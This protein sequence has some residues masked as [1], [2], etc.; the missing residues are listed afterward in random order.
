MDKNSL[1][2]RITIGI[3][4]SL[5]IVAS[6]ITGFSVYTTKSYLQ[7]EVRQKLQ[8][9]YQGMQQMFS[10][11][12]DNALAHAQALSRN[13]HIIEAAKRRDAQALFR[14]TTPLMKDG[15]LDYMVITDPKGFAII[16]TH[17]PGKIPKP[18]DSIAN[19][20]NVAQ[21]IAGKPFVGIEEGKVVRLSVRAG[22]PLY[23]ETGALVGVIST[24]YVI[25]QNEIVDMAKKMFGAEFMLFLD[26]ERVAAT[27]VGADGSRIAGDKLDDPSIVQTVLKEGKVYV[28]ETQISG[29][30]YISSYG[31]LTGAG[32]KIIGMIGLAIPAA[33]TEQITS[34]LT[35]RIIGVSAAALLMVVA[36]AVFFIRRLFKPLQLILARIME[37]SQ[38]N[39]SVAE[40]TI[41]SN[42]EIGKLAAGCNTML[43]RL[44]TLI[45]QTAHSAEQVASSSQ[46]LTASA[47]QSAQV[48]NQV[49]QSITEVAGG[50][51]KQLQA[52]TRTTVIVEQMAE[53]VQ[54]IAAHAGTVAET[55]AK[56][57]EGAQAGSKVVENAVARMNQVEETV[58]RS[59]GVVTKLGDRS[60]EI[61]SIVDTIAGIAGQTNLL[62]LNAAIEAA[63]AGEQ[64]RGFAVVAE[65]VRKLAE[66]SQQAAKQIGQLIAE[67]Q[68]DT[69]DAVKTMNDGTSEVRTGTEAVHEAGLAF[70][71]LYESISKVSSQV[72]DISAAIQQVASGSQQVEAA[73]SEI[74]DIC[75]AATGQSQAVSAA[76]EEQ[77]ATS[78]E[79]AAA[80]QALAKMAAELT[81]CIDMF[82]I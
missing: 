2:V 66:Q 22:A 24:G 77:S 16:R 79:I 63:R 75:K 20:V 82:K 49:A 4:V 13:P 78:E 76:T 17:E 43:G 72:A 33:L 60:K 21:A 27:L 36:A 53:G 71:E 40:L 50:A 41:Q 25:S 56:S 28:G 26:Q 62:A 7:G 19:Q 5:V 3:T 68:N 45:R 44:R 12:Q 6:L 54:T 10:M 29:Q 81:Q 64:G 47:E 80:S 51:E 70:R 23:D 61:G 46:Q 8:D 9:S 65:E 57:S 59:A 42:D 73:M 34:T 52:V 38:G 14:I 48:A 58:S 31:P 74:D 32:G 35:L 55:A 1:L 30:N 67:I 69:K 39:L 11:Y 15:K 18:D 37:V